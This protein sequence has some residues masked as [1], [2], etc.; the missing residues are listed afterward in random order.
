[1]QDAPG[2]FALGEESGQDS[3]RSRAEEHHRGSER[4]LGT[5]DGV[6]GNR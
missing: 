2:A 6:D 3:D 5:S 1:M 4:N